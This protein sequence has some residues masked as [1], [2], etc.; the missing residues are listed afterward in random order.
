MMGLQLKARDFL[1]GFSQDGFRL[2][3][4]C[5]GNEWGGFLDPLQGTEIASAF[6]RHIG[7]CF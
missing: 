4:F 5:S 7:E 3:F 2:C 1:L 6:L